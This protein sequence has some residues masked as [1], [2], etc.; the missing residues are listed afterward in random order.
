MTLIARG[1]DAWSDGAKAAKVLPTIG[2]TG[3]TAYTAFKT[4][5]ANRLEVLL[6]VAADAATT[7]HLA[8]EDTDDGTNYFR[9]EAINSVS[10]GVVDQDSARWDCPGGTGLYK[11]TATVDPGT[12]V[13]ILAARTGG[14]ATTLLAK[15]RLIRD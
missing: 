10:S 14:T 4:R 6:N 9:V 3:L 5:G 1:I 15:A 8:I 7:V 12:K 13:R 2:T 11:V